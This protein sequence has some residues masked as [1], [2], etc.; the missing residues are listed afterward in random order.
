M[1]TY[2]ALPSVAAS[3]AG[4]FSAMGLLIAVAWFV[5]VA[6]LDFLDLPRV[7]DGAVPL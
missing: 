1:S 6:A 4:L 7:C 5:A 2:G 3:D